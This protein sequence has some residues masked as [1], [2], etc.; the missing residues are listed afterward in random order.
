M[1][2][3]SADASTPATPLIAQNHGVGR[4]SMWLTIRISVGNPNPMSTPDGTIAKSATI[5]RTGSAAEAKTLIRAESHKAG[6]L[7]K[8]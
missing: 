1:V 4:W 3:A 6:R 5:A 7:C 8:C 2:T